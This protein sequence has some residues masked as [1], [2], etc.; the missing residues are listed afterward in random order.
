ME[1]IKK[2]KTG[3]QYKT[4]QCSQEIILSKQIISYEI[5]IY[6]FFPKLPLL[7]AG[8]EERCCVDAI[9]EKSQLEPPQSSAF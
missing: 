4:E 7:T 2:K 9:D 8:C 6:A 3:S 5:A 1:K